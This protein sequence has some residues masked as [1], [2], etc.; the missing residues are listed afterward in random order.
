LGI[1][2]QTFSKFRPTTSRI[3][4]ILVHQLVI[5][6]LTKFMPVDFQTLTKSQLERH[7]LQN[8]HII[9]HSILNGMD[10]HLEGLSLNIVYKSSLPR[11]IIQVILWL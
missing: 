7:S 1:Q 8:S 5:K 2:T 4:Y 10:L 6:G 11:I 9:R 3:I